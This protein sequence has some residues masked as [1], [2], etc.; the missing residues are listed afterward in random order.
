M[1]KISWR[2]TLTFLAMGALSLL[3]FWVGHSVQIGL[4]GINPD[5]GVIF[6]SLI[7]PTA[8]IAFYAHSISRR[9]RNLCTFT[10]KAVQGEFGTAAMTSTADE[11]TELT[12]NLNQLSRQMDG[13]TQQAIQE[14]HKLD[15]VLKGMQEGIIAL[16]HLGRVIRINSAA[17]SMFHCQKERINEVYLEDLIDIAQ[18]KELSDKV[19]QGKMAEE[20]ELNLGLRSLMIQVNPILDEEGQV[21]GAV[22]V[23]RDV[24]ELRHLEQVRTDFV[25]NVSHELRTPLTSIRGFV[26]T[27]LDG[28]AESPE[29]RERFLKII[30]S[31]TLRM[32]RLVE[33]LLTLT[34]LEHRKSEN[35]Q[36][37]GMGAKVRE[38]Y[39]KIRPLVEPY[40]AGKGLQLD[41]DLPENLPEVVLGEDLLSQVFLNLIENAIKYTIEG[42]IWL[43]ALRENGNIRIE[44][45]D[46]GSGIPQDSLNRIFERFYRVDKARSREQGGTGL[47]LSI[48]KHILEGAGGK[49][50]VAS[51]MGEGSVFTC[52]IP[53]K[54]K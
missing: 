30:D 26:E 11:I 14:N 39:E 49:I 40:A 22:I 44:I 27:L 17:L 51:V 43:Q 20:T 53:I 24:T 2:L 45:G 54:S 21:K 28:A 37:N 9:L 10:A 15:A 36:E 47:G 23:S 16:D 33:D 18:L 6:L 50:S 7:L 48:V 4:E 41:I 8:V 25:A 29:L 46:T 19:L 34:R 31:E 1:M 5:W 35:G 3:F 38:A 42:Q 13:I 52:L 12:E 32:Q